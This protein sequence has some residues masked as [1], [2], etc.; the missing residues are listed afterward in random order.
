MQKVLG[1]V[2]ALMFLPAATAADPITV[3]ANA[4]R[5]F[6]VG[7]GDPRAL[8]GVWHQN[9]TPIVDVNIT[10]DLFD[11]QPFLDLCTLCRS[12]DSFTPFIVISGESVGTVTAFLGDPRDSSRFNDL[13]L[14]GILTLQAGSITL[15]ADAPD[16][17]NV[18]L[19]LTFSGSL[20]ARAGT[21]D[22]LRVQPFSFPGTAFVQFRTSA[23]AD[24]ERLFTA[25]AFDF[26]AS[27]IAAP[28]PEPASLLLVGGGLAGLAWRRR[29]LSPKP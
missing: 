21:A 5:V 14:G 1:A 20:T 12:G 9:R 27:D 8:I 26:I 4:A 18:F 3:T 6:V 16:L 10:G 25:Q 17:F 19:P 7:G 11:A 23:G 13:T 2:I 22:I 28:V 15:P 24:G 29:R